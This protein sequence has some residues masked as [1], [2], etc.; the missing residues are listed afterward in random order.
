MHWHL[1]AKA[2]KLKNTAA[3]HKKKR[4]NVLV[5]VSAFVVC[6]IC[7]EVILRVAGYK[8]G[9]LSPTWM[10]FKEVDSLE[11]YLSFYTDEHGIF[12]ANNAYFENEFFIN[13]DGF[14]GADFEPDSQSRTVLFLGDSYTWGSKAEPVTNSFVDLVANEG[15]HVYNT[16]IPGADPPQYLA[17]AESYVT[18]LKPDVVCLMFYAGNDFIECERDVKPFHNIFHI[19]NA[20]WLSPYIENGYEGCPPLV[21]KYYLDKYKIGNNAPFWRRLAGKTAIGTLAMSIPIRME[22]RQLWQQN[23]STALKYVDAI[24]QV[25]ELNG[26]RFHLFVIPLHTKIN[27]NLQQTYESIFESYRV[28][29]PENINKKD[30]HPWPNGHLNN[31]GHAKYAKKILEV[32]NGR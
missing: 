25:C 5:A 28:H 13:K 21:Y 31:D 29:I 9:L 27:A 18:K 19:T 23:T 16:G 32:I 14:R 15:F 22:E 12:R 4:I 8:T 3:M 17:I 1:K 11:T 30:F 26:S 20:G 10:N 6:L 2:H 7:V 24:K